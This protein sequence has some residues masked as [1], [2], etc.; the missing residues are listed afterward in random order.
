MPQRLQL[1]ICLEQQW[2]LQLQLR[3]VPAAPASWGGGSGC[4][5]SEQIMEQMKK[6]GDCLYN[7]LLSNPPPKVRDVKKMKLA[8]V[9]ALASAAHALRPT[10]RAQ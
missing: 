2:R 3:R 4:L 6:K 7:S 10:T 1:L 8:V 5:V 9:I